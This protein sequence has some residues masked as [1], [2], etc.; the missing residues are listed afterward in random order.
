MKTTQKS[1]IETQRDSFL[2]RNSLIE[3]T[4][5]RKIQQQA[6]IRVKSSEGER[7]KSE[8]FLK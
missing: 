6:V 7:L 1:K 4:D 8:N 5:W 2:E 3:P